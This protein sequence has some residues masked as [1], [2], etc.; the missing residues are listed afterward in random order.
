MKM[1][2]Y[3]KEYFTGAEIIIW[4]VSSA[5]IILSFCIFDRENYLTL[6][7]SMVGVTSLIFI[8]KGNPAGQ[9]LMVIFSSLYAVISYNYSYYGEMV[10]YLGMGA[11]M[12]VFTF[13]S[14]LRNPY[15]D[16][17][18]EVKVNSLSKIDFVLMIVLT[19][20]VTQLFYYIL[21]FFNTANLVPSTISITTSFLGVYLMFRRS[22]YYA[23]AFVLNDIVLICLW[24]LASFDNIQYISVTVCFAAFLVN[25]MYG[26]LSWRKM[27]VRQN[28]N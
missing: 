1:L 14:W 22:P 9:L 13:I 23:L 18:S 10:T 24:I 27:K 11:P 20:L 8:A 12:A 21:K 5:V 6:L 3:I 2:N 28:Q 26:Y 19:V 15:K 25:D 7:A 17:K 16:N 4:S